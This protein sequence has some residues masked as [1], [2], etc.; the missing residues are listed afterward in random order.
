MTL[1][2]NTIIKNMV[3]CVAKYQVKNISLHHHLLKER[4]MK[5]IFLTSL[6]T[7]LTLAAANAN[8]S[9]TPLSES[10]KKEVATIIHFPDFLGSEHMT[11]VKALLTIDASGQVIVA[12]I[13]SSNEQL[14][15]DVKQ[16]LN[17][18]KLENTSGKTEQIILTLHFKTV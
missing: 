18:L 4:N 7:V 1:K 14:I 12:E 5:K 10:L 13:N 11:S 15:E 2:I 16:K 6:V 9:T 3:L 8:N 17:K